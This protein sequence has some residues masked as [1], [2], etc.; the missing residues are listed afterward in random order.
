MNEI[1]VKESFKIDIIKHPELDFNSQRFLAEKIKMFIKKVDS[2]YYGPF[3]TLFQSSGF[4]KTRACLSLVNENFYVVYC[5]LRNSFSTGYPPRSSLARFF[6]KNWVNERILIRNF[7]SYINLF[8]D[9]IKKEKIDCSDFFNKYSHESH[10]ILPK[11]MEEKLKST[12]A[13]SEFS[14]YAGKNPIVFIFDESLLMLGKSLEYDYFILRKVLSELQGNLF[15]LFLD[16]FTNP[17]E[18]NLSTFS[19]FSKGIYKIEK[20]LFE[21]IYL[22]PNWD[23]FVNYSDIE[24]IYDT[25]K[26]ENI[27]CFGRVLWGSWIFTKISSFEKFEYVSNEE[28][29]NLAI[30]KLI[31]GRSF[32]KI[33]LDENECLAIASSRIGTIRLKNNSSKQEL[34]AKHLAIC[35]FVNFEK[36]IF[37]IE[38]PSE[39]ILAL[40]AASLMD[41]IGLEKILDKLIEMIEFSLIDIGE[42]GVV[43]AKLILIQTIDKITSKKYSKIT[44][45]LNLTRV[46]EF[47]QELYGKCQTNCG[48]FENGW[49]CMNKEKFETFVCPIKIIK[50]QLRNPIELL[51]GFINF[52]HFT[53][54]NCPLSK[55]SL[56]NSL[57]RCAAIECKS[58]QPGIDLVIPVC[59][60][61]KSLTSF[62]VIAIK[63]TLTNEPY[64]PDYIVEAIGA[65]I[66]SNFDLEKPYVILYNQLGEFKRKNYL[67][68]KF[69]YPEGDI[70][71]KQAIIYSE[72]LSEDTFPNLGEMLIQKLI[73]ISNSAEKLLKDKNDKKLNEII[74]FSIRE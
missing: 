28:I 9:L 66:S 1:L 48:S 71:Q 54:P 26:F 39:P 4:G 20:L 73:K 32:K 12:D 24:N 5:C 38:Y 36:N 52:N 43:I 18:S 63:V 53:K 46:G 44:K 40:A 14:Y 27:C 72:G 51:N 7:K 34:V 57:K 61:S 15:V 60:E 62:S 56:R 50:T 11:L 69:N 6:E 47:L 49:N 70:D 25:V 2:K 74:C 29:L 22:L 13:D 17:F 31:G 16:T 19:D 55:A 68:Q 33:V 21:P 3:T 23:L 65:T 30:S 67:N 10:D 58:M 42:K 64:R 41:E 59:L 45:Y 35:T 8:I 37:E